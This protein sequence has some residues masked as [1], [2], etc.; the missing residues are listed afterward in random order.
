MGLALESKVSSKK[1]GV[2]W[3]I[4]KCIIFTVVIGAFSVL[5]HAFTSAYM[6]H[7]HGKPEFVKTTLVIYSFIEKA[8]VAVGYVILGTKIP[9]KNSKLRAFTYA[10][11]VWA[12]DYLPQVMGLWL[13]DGP[14]AQ[15]SFSASIVLSDSLTYLMS[16]LVLSI[17]FKKVPE[18]TKRDCNQAK[19]IKAIM[20]SAIGFPVLIALVDQVLARVYPAFSS[21]GAM[22]VSDGQKL[23]FYI[24]FYSW[25]ILSGALFVV[26]YRLTEYNELDDKGWIKFA[27]KYIGLLWTPVVLIMIVFGTEI[28]PTVAYGIIF[29]ICIFLICWIN[30]RIL[31]AK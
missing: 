12:S 17:L 6:D 20:T 5:C 22:Q 1:N 4:L 19:Y 30:N 15:M 7:V 3:I 8:L 14:I 26:F 10:I 23:M 25:F 11:L 16:G 29:A 31:E 27:I 28:T 21:A 18:R 9:V 13:A 2:A 24:N